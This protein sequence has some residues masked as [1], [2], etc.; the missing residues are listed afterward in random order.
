MKTPD[1]RGTPA[2]GNTKV[3]ELVLRRDSLI[4]DYLMVIIGTREESELYGEIMGLSDAITIIK[5]VSE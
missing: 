3:D 4:D 1:E 2:Q 5:G